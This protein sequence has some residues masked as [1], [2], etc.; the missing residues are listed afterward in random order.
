MPL[1]H[2]ID[3]RGERLRIERLSFADLAHSVDSRRKR[4]W[5]ER[6]CTE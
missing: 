1:A 4:L 6:K 5:V 2:S 3:S